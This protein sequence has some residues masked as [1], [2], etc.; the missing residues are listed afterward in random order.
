MDKIEQKIDTIVAEYGAEVMTS[1]QKNNLKRL[2]KLR[3]GATKEILQQIDATYNQPVNE[4]LLLSDE[5]IENSITEFCVVLEGH[6]S[7]LREVA[8]AQLAKDQKR[9]GFVLDMSSITI[10]LMLAD[11]REQVL[12]EVGEDLCILCGNTL[13]ENTKAGEL[14][15]N[16]LSPIL[17][18]YHLI[19]FQDNLKQGKK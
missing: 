13:I 8:K 15:T 10:D 4:D 6:R 7:F 1:V 9:E 2:P 16:A 18:K 5:E 14:L 19:V 3:E 11:K 12:K 17:K